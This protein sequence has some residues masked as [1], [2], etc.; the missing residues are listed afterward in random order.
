MARTGIFKF[1]TNRFDLWIILKYFKL[2]KQEQC[3]KKYVIIFDTNQSMKYLKKTQINL[4]NF[5][6]S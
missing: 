3:A 1:I 2:L 4:K 5:E 6:V